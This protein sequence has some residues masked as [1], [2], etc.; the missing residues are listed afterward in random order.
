[1]KTTVTYD[2]YNILIDKAVIDISETD[3]YELSISD[4]T[5]EDNTVTKK[6]DLKAINSLAPDGIVLS[7][8]HTEAKELQLLI[9]QFVI[10][11]QKSLT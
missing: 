3:K 10:N 8:T 6:L 4:V 7:M 1:M 5:N 9:S 11:L 2:N